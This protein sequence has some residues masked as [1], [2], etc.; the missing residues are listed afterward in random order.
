M[1]GRVVLCP[2]G[3]LTISL[4]EVLYIVDIFPIYMCSGHLAY[5]LST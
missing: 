1:S 3:S 5:V 2:L 4:L